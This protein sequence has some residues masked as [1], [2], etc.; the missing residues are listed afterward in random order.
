M[1]KGT[2]GDVSALKKYKYLLLLQ[3]FNTLNVEAFR[4]VPLGC[5]R[6]T[7]DVLEHPFPLKI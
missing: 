4:N 2:C 3:Y 7:E 6:G 5:S 1:E